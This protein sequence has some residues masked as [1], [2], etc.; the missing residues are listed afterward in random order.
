MK[1]KIIPHLYF[2]FK[3]AHLQILS[4]H[5]FFIMKK[6]SA[7][8]LFGLAIL[9]LNAQ[10]PNYT[11]TS[12]GITV[13]GYDNLKTSLDAKLGID[14]L[15]F[16][17]EALDT[18][19]FSFKFLVENFTLGIQSPEPRPLVCR[20]ATNGQSVRFSL[21]GQPCRTSYGPYVATHLRP[22]HHVL[23]AYLARACQESIKSPSAYILKE[24]DAGR[25]GRSGFDPRAPHIFFGSPNGD[26]IDKA[27]NSKVLLD[28]YLI[29]CT[30]AEKGYKVR[31]TIGGAVFILARWEPYFID[32]LPLGETHIKLELLDKNDKPL[33]TGYSGAER[34]VHLYQEPE[35]K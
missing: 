10:T 2:I 3:S 1:Y 30:L 35:A 31:A 24:F 18:G 29:N 11:A 14:P 21:D 12:R 19:T 6:I 34:T 32:G 33:A 5:L 13:T 22:G 8:L 27:E 20:N 16:A 15:A 23:F 9:R 4:L 26:Y 25:K 7:F 17:R 28:F